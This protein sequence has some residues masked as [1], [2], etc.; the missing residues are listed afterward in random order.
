M[1]RMDKDNHRTG[2]SVEHLDLPLGLS[3]RIVREAQRTIEE[4]ESVP[5]NTDIELFSRLYVLFSKGWEELK[6]AR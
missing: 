6:C 1:T 2:F 3:W 4:W 5:G